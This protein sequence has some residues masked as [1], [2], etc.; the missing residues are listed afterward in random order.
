MNIQKIDAEVAIMNRQLIDEYGIDTVTSNPIFRIVWNTDQM[1]KVHA[2]FVDRTPSG[3]FIREVTESRIVHKYRGFKLDRY[4]LERLVLVPEH[5]QDVLLG[6]KI[7]YEGLWTF[8]SSNGDYLPPN[9]K[10]AKF[11]IDTVLA[12]QSTLKKM[13]D[14]SDKSDRVSLNKYRDDD[15]EYSQEA[16]IEYR[17]KLADDLQ[18]ELFGNLSGLGGQTTKAGTDTIIMPS[19]YD[20]ITGRN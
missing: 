17:K 14:P 11:V 13:I 12:A 7:S 19:N 3:Q 8:S 16:S 9:Y 5:Q 2:T 10:A 18:V 1:E 6:L 4:V 15:P 20:S